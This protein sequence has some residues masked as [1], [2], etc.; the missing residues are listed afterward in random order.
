[1]RVLL[2]HRSAYDDWSFP[3]GKADQGETPEETAIREVMEETGYHCHIVTPLGSTRYP[4]S[5]G[6]KEVHWF[7][8]RPLP[9]SPGFTKNAE[10]DAIRWLSPRKTWDALQYESDRA[11]L[12]KADLAGLSLTGTIWLL[13]HAEAGSRAAWNGKDSLR[14]LTKKGKRQTATIRDDLADSGVERV[15]SSPYLRCIQTVEPLAATIGADLEVSD[16][17]AEGSDGDMAFALLESLIGTNVVLSTHGDVL[18]TL[19][20]RMRSEGLKLKGKPNTSKAS[21]WRIEVE[22]GRFTRGRY[23]PPPGGRSG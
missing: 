10:V 22:N 2:A 16:A 23:S 11:L 20:S 21:I 6:V 3:K 7:A 13:R 4:I 19:L 17:L 5:N 15:M 12:K 9:D 18:T 8:M 14:P 1:M